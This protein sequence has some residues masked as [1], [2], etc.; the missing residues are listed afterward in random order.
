[1]TKFRQ[2]AIRQAGFTLLELLL[3]VA[4][5]SSLALAATTF[6]D[7][8]D[9]QRR[10]EETRN[11]LANIRRAIIGYPNLS[12][13]GEAV[14]GGFVADMGRLPRNLNELFVSGYCS[15]PA[16]ISKSVCESNSGTWTE[17]SAFNVMGACSNVTKTTK[18][19]CETD[20]PD[21]IWI[22]LGTGWRGPYLHAMPESGGMI[23][24][25]GW[26]NGGNAPGADFGWR[27]AV[28]DIDDDATPDDFDNTLSVQSMGSDGAP[29]GGSYAA[30]Y[31]VSTA[32]LVER[33][34]HNVDLTGGIRVRFQ[35]P[36]DGSGTALPLSAT[37]VC[38]R[39]YYAS[40]G[41]IASVASNPE[42]LA[43][44]FV[45]DGAS[46]EVTFTFPS[47]GRQWIP[48]GMR[49]V[50]IF[51]HSGSSGSCQNQNEAYP[52]AA[53]GP[54]RTIALL[55]RTTLPMIEWRME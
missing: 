11:R 42:S 50:G 9:D 49:A 2:S 15:N 22:E 6:V 55:P 31:P 39:I 23:Y 41:A 47:T 53:I 4:I 54:A 17:D 30:D 1:M 51:K 20:S 28:T 33:G 43:S 7:N 48:W 37:T 24:R 16:Y 40:N 35:N 10:F 3:V 32:V 44:G 52:S 14:I 36:A 34:D 27:V 29:G 21:N 8:A 13:G 5:L 46:K 12:A 38:L 25:D 18:S 45:A 19:D 26:G